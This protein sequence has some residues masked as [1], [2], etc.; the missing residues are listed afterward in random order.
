MTNVKLQLTTGLLLA[1]SI[2]GIMITSQLLIVLV[3]IYPSL[4]KAGGKK[5]LDKTTVTF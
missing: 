1:L 2:A 4:G 3:S 5:A